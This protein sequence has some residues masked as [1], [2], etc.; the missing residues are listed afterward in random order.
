[1]T[2][3]NE[4]FE[5]LLSAELARQLEPQRGKAAAAFAAQIAAEAAERQAAER[6][7]REVVGGSRNQAN[8][9]RG[10]VGKRAMWMWM[11][12]PSLIAA[13]LA[14]VITLQF[15]GGP[16]NQMTNND[17]AGTGSTPSNTGS[18]FAG[19]Q[20]TAGV[21]T[22]VMASQRD[23]IIRNQPGGIIIQNNQPM[24]EIHQQQIRKYQWQDPNDHATYSITEEPTETVIPVPAQPY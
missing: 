8:W 20:P 15:A 10:E 4:K 23:E 13:C 14:V 12:L 2:M 17:I 6:A 5:E 21:G 7:A 11:G 24:R 3:R 18:T 19:M 16:S 1:M 9:A 22:G